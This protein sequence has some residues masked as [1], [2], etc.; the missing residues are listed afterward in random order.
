VLV[1][2]YLQKNGD[3]TVVI[4]NFSSARIHTPD[5][6]ALPGS[7]LRRWAENP[8]QGFVTDA[9]GMTLAPVL[10]SNVFLRLEPSGLVAMPLQGRFSLF[11]VS[12]PYADAPAAEFLDH[13]GSHRW[14]A[15]NRLEN[16]L[17]AGGDGRIGTPLATAPVHGRA[18]VVQLLKFGRHLSVMILDGKTGEPRIPPCRVR[19]AL[20][21]FHTPHRHASRSLIARRT[22][23]SA[24]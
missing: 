2:L 22:S 5:A 15:G 12:F 6:G 16:G 3:V 17:R 11:G 9:P 21:S 19:G 18:E 1:I 20:R 7:E 4:N 8:K 24:C 23:Y 14:S 13:T 10:G